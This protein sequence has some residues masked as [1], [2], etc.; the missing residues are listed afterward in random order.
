VS[1]DILLVRFSAI[2]DVLLMTPLVRALRQRHPEAR[3][4]VVTKARFAPIFDHNPR[5]T[6]VIGWN[7]GGS[8]RELGAALRAREFT[9]RLD[10]HGSSRSRALRW[11]AG[12]RWSGYPKHRIAREL[13]IRAKRDVYRDRRPVAERYFDAARDLDVRPDAG[14][15]EFF[16]AAPALAAADEFLAG[17]RLGATRQLLA[18][19][20]GAAHF[21]KRWPPHH[22]KALVRL[23]IEAGNDVVVVGGTGDREVAEAVVEAGGERVA[24]AAGRFDLTGSAALLRRSRALVSGDTGV[25]HLATAV[26]TPVVTLFGPTVEAFGFFPYHAK[27]TVLQRELPCRPCSTHGTA[28]CPLKHHRC[29]QD[30][31]PDA[32]LTAL[33]RLPR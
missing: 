33:R 23:L 22:W 26:G 28:A 18:V 31:Q 4:T 16:L 10:L 32:V 8:L 6:E 30:L 5:V 15:L 3:I 11:L 29:L 13:L 25:M 9:H 12:G 2:G 17:H 20:P 7:E 24:S 1:P 14:P 27:A 19:A 21:T